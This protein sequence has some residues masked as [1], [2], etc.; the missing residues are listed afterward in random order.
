MS[1]PVELGLFDPD[2]EEEENEDEDED[3]EGNQY[4]DEDPPLTQPSPREMETRK[5]LQSLSLT[6]GVL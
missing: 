3:P 4:E 1:S 5:S 2:V 6:V